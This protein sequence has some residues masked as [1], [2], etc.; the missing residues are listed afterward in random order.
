MSLHYQPNVL[1]YITRLNGIILDLESILRRG[2]KAKVQLCCKLFNCI[3]T[4][5]LK[6]NE[7]TDVRKRDLMDYI[8]STFIIRLT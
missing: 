2:N 8:A 6:N 5:V 1:L 7:S 3:E 4:L